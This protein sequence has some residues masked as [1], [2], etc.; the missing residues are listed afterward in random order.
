[1]RIEQ[2]LT[3][4][5]RR[6][7]DKVALVC[8]DRRISYAD[9]DKLAWRMSDVLRRRPA[10]ARGDRVVLFMENSVEAV[11]GM[12]AILATGAVFAFVNTS[13]KAGKLTEL[14]NDLGATALITQTQF[15]SIIEQV[16]PLVPSLRTTFVADAQDSPGHEGVISLPKAMENAVTGTVTSVGT[17]LD[18]AYVVYTSGSTGASKGVMM[19]HKT[20]LAGADSVIDYLDNTADDVILSAVPL[21]SGYGLHQV[22]MSVRFGGTVVL[23]KSFAAPRTIMQKL[24]QEKAT[25]LPLIPTTIALLLQMK[26]LVAG[27]FSHLRYITS[28][29]VP[30]PQDHGVRLQ[31]LFP[32]ARIFSMYGLTECMRVMCLPPEQ[33]KSRP[34]SVG[35][36]LPNTEAYIVNGNSERVGPEE[37]G[38]LVIRGPTLL[39]GYW[40]NPIATNEVLRPG[41]S[42]GEKVL[43]TGDLFRMDQEGYLYFI[44]RKDDI[45]KSCGEKVSP[46]EVENVLYGL[47][48]V[49]C[50]AV[51]GVPDP[52][53]GMALK[54]LIVADPDSGLSA[55]DV[56]AHCARQL[57]D[58][59]V[60][61]FVEFRGQLP[62]TE[63]GKIHRRQLQLEALNAASCRE[64]T[65]E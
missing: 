59:K 32:C 52:L 45:I 7:P 40:Q 63:T 43:H 25:G 42:P 44:A 56:K 30:L 23:E 47:R 58:Y 53:L 65:G 46:L 33:L 17:D 5:A 62:K 1:M 11:A 22:I 36:A 8:G 4:T 13:T 28:V 37:V 38:E 35:K 16:I 48:S 55:Y 61:V 27:S 9:L 26:K 51:I 39:K 29:S 3:E 14:L 12:F 50:A 15:L 24:A 18:L 57:E 64:V 31:E 2:L 54:A 6:R 10:V 60:P 19:I 20:A 21:S 41:P 34:T 49:R